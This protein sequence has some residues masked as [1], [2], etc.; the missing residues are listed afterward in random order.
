MGF[1][2][3]RCS[4]AHGAWGHQWLAALVVL[5]TFGGGVDALVISIPRARPIGRVNVYVNSKGVSS[6]LGICTLVKYDP[7]DSDLR[8]APLST[9]S[10][11]GGIAF[12]SAG[13][14]HTFVLE[15]E[16]DDVDILAVD[17]LTLSTFFSGHAEVSECVGRHWSKTTS[18]HS[19][20]WGEKAS[21]H[22]P[23]TFKKRK[24]FEDGS[25]WA[26][27]NP[28]VYLGFLAQKLSYVLCSVVNAIFLIPS[29]IIVAF[30][31]SDHPKNT[32][33]FVT[34]TMCLDHV[35]A[36]DAQ[37]SPTH[38]YPPLQESGGDM[39][40]GGLTYYWQSAG[41]LLAGMM[42]VIIPL[43]FVRVDRC[44]N[45]CRCARKTCP[46]TSSYNNK[47]G[48]YCCWT[49]ATGTP[50][51]QNYHSHSVKG[52]TTWFGWS[53]MV[54][55]GLPFTIFMSLC[56]PGDMHCI[57]HL[58]QIVWTKDAS[59]KPWI[60]GADSLLAVLYLICLACSVVLVAFVTKGQYSAGAKEYGPIE[61]D[62]GCIG[63]VAYG[64]RPGSV[65]DRSMP[66]TPKTVERIFTPT[67]RAPPR[68]AVAG[69]P[70]YG[71]FRRLIFWVCLFS[72]FDK[73]ECVTCTTCR[74]GIPGC[75]GGGACPLLAT[76]AAN[77]AAITAGA[78][79][80]MSVVS[81]L[82]HS[83]IRHLSGDVLRALQAIARNPAGGTMPDLTAMDQQQ[84]LSAYT[85][86]AADV[87]SIRNEVGARVVDPG[88]TA[89]PLARWQALLTA[90][91][92]A[93]RVSIYSEI[94]GCNAV[95]K[96]T[97]VWAV[98]SHIVKDDK[99]TYSVGTSS[100]ESSGGR[101]RTKLSIK[102]VSD[103]LQFSELLHVWQVLL[104]A[105]GICNVLMAAQFIQEVVYDS[106]SQLSFS[107]SSAFA[108][109]TKH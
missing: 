86:G 74:D 70:L 5:C 22:S 79:A 38:M 35:L 57:E 94:D 9:P 103:F 85:S 29:L 43:C 16:L 67:S 78:T 83:Y 56:H 75:A 106:M 32:I 21:H 12:P 81:I 105:L 15:P 92:D 36:T 23:I 104:H 97:F 58:D 2:N 63:T 26:V 42:L 10:K 50:C 84:I 82:P 108:C 71:M 4:P 30:S 45:L 53:R 100:V 41:Y 34:W 89:A 72:F 65:S 87:E 88:I 52:Y 64:C 19:V 20:C 73:G 98:A 27:G 91:K 40:T 39:Q 68:L 96:H 31:S 76:T 95:G 17:N 48:E 62:T 80:V 13:E 69:T 55:W 3:A 60:A 18:Q 49:C 99:T 44:D 51:K 24:Y 59:S 33:L 102:L 6:Q 101:G 28:G 46:C 61:L 107:V 11:G 93:P 109:S 14:Y 77:I 90:L 37:I 66:S 54:R 7:G 1:S 8:L 47:P 25:R